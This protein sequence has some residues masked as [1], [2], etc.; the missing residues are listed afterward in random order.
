[1]NQK[2][3][4][5]G[6]FEEFLRSKNGFR[7]RGS[8]PGPAD[9]VH[10][11]RDPEGVEWI[12]AISLHRGVSRMNRGTIDYYLKNAGIAPEEFWGDPSNFH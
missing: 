2:D 3:A 1:M 10:L 12:D 4:L 9:I 7:P 8:E 5:T 6:D 11:T